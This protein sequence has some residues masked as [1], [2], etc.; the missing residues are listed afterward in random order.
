MAFAL[1]MADAAAIL[2][3]KQERRLHALVIAGTLIKAS[4]D[5]GGPSP[6]THGR[7]HPLL[8]DLLGMEVESPRF[9]A[10][11]ELARAAL[12]LCAA[13]KAWR[14]SDERDEGEAAAG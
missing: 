5:A 11:V 9:A 13:A 2:I 1:E 8:V 14:A 6:A 12:A 4:H 3:A 7:V 10:S